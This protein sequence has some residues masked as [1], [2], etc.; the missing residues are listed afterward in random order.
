MKLTVEAG[1]HAPALLTAPRWAE[2]SGEDFQARTR[3]PSS[4]NRATE[5]QELES[6]KQQSQQKENVREGRTLEG[7]RHK[8]GRGNKSGGAL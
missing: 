1:M 3:M 2:K 4:K 8:M 5:R 7:K 6:E